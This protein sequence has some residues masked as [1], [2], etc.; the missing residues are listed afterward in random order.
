MT[1]SRIG[2][3]GEGATF[4]LNYRGRI[5][6][7][8]TGL[9]SNMSIA[10]IDTLGYV[11]DLNEV[12]DAIHHEPKTLLQPTLVS[13]EA[14]FRDGKAVAL[15][16]DNEAVGYVRFTPLL[17]AEKKENLD[18]PER[19]P[20]IYETGTAI[21]LRSE[22]G[23]K[24][25]PKMRTE[26]IKMAADDIKKGKILVLGTTKNPRVV[27][28]LDDAINHTG[29]S[30]RIV[31]RNLYSSVMAH[32]CVCEGSFGNGYQFGTSCHKEPTVQQLIQITNHKWDE[33]VKE[34][35]EIPCTIY[36][37]DLELARRTEA[38]LLELFGTRQAV[39]D[40]LKGQGQYD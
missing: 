25:Y 31:Q 9:P 32:T 17:D 26:L 23:N 40:A 19:I 1:E 3:E 7:A 29:I 21:I 24:Y 20:E 33:V 27:E 5:V 38:E 11:P 39:V 30:F 35:G 12:L 6:S 8:E 28:S 34:D 16:K 13:M 36:V 22:R 18:L 14:S 15:M 10:N 4:A 37:S 2:I